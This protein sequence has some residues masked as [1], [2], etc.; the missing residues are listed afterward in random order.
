MGEGGGER[1][2]ESERSPSPFPPPQA[3]VLCRC[4]VCWCSLCTLLRGA[5]Q[6]RR[7]RICR[8]EKEH[9]HRR[10]QNNEKGDTEAES[11]SSPV[12]QKKGGT[13]A[14]MDEERLRDRGRM[15]EGEDD[16]READ[17]QYSHLPPTPFLFLCPTPSA[18][19]RRLAEVNVP[20]ECAATLGTRPLSS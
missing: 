17:G 13:L 20:E 5:A 7:T 15:A 2:T 11:P 8:A 14:S 3:C 12:R 4:F 18:R 10:Q 1:E 16:G 9:Q 19:R 6:S